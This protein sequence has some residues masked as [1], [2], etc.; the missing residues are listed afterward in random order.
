[1]FTF[2]ITPK[3]EKWLNSVIK[4][5]KLV[6]GKSEIFQHFS[7]RIKKPSTSSNKCAHFVT[8]ITMIWPWPLMLMKYLC[9]SE[10][11]LRVLTLTGGWTQ[12][13]H[14]AFG[15]HMVRFQKRF[16][17]TNR[18]KGGSCSP[19]QISA[20]SRAWEETPSIT[21]VSLSPRDFI[22]IFYL[23]TEGPNE[24]EAPLLVG[25]RK[26]VGGKR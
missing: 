4:I 21:W 14:M 5:E 18:K 17:Q 20:R 13:I 25:R 6:T 11:D 3:I 23:L 2:E 1:M 15:S 7:K 19:G 10:A 12:P 8:M 26:V 9:S 16:R 22:F 24:C